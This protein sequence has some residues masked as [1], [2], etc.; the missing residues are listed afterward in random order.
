MRGAAW[1]LIWGS[2]RLLAATVGDEHLRKARQLLI[3]RAR[4]RALRGPDALQLA[5]ALELKRA[6]LVSVFV[7]DDQKLRQI[8]MMEGITTLNPEQPIAPQ[9]LRH[10]AHLC[11]R[12]P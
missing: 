7:A 1:K 10:T 3:D 2:R 8:A 11:S 5:I 9:T 12:S 6:G 4:T